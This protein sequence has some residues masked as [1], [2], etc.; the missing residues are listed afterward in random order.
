MSLNKKQYY[1]SGRTLKSRGNQ[2]MLNS[3]EKNAYNPTR[4]L[5]K[6]RESFV[7]PE[8][9]EMKCGGLTK[10]PDGG[11]TKKSMLD[12]S[13]LTYTPST[14]AMNAMM[15]ARLAYANEFGNPS[16]KRMVVAPDQP[17]VYTGEEYDKDFD[18]PA[19]VPA[20]SIG[21]HYM[22]EFDN[23]AVPFIQQGPK[24]LYFNES[25]SISDKEAIRFDSPEDA[26]Y[27]AQH[28]KEVAPDP[29]Y[30]EEENIPETYNLQRALELGYTPDETGHMPSVD[31][32][33]GM[34]LKSIDHPTSWK[35]YLY[36]SLNRELG[37]NYNVR[38][39]PEGYFGKRQL[40]YV[41]KK[42]GGS[43]PKMDNGGGFLDRYAFNMQ[44]PDRK[45]GLTIGAGTQYGTY[46]GLTGSLNAAVPF[47]LNPRDVG[48][49]SSLQG[50]VYAGRTQFGPTK[51]VSLGY[52]YDNQ[53][54]K[55]FFRGDAGYDQQL[56][57]MGTVQAGQRF[58]FELRDKKR[59]TDYTGSFGYGFGVGLHSKNDPRTS[60]VIPTMFYGSNEQRF[61][62]TPA[63]RNVKYQLGLQGDISR[64][65]G[66][67]KLTLFGKANVDPTQ[68]KYR[69]RDL[70]V[71]VEEDRR[72]I[73]A[74]TSGQLE[75]SPS[76]T[77]GAKYDINKQ[78]KDRKIQS[79]IEKQKAKE[80][81][82]LREQEAIARREEERKRKQQEESEFV[83]EDRKQF[84]GEV[85][86]LT[87]KEIKELR[88]GGHIVI[89]Q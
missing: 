71:P 8:L 55:S 15:K 81:A 88:K 9:K 83:K 51:G 21:T 76:F 12:N 10:M 45:K 13:E 78:F 75:W 3:I 69:R 2:T 36:G 54:Y 62:P 79:R 73:D 27:F 67:G 26:S 47:K 74:A 70:S 61:T 87:D 77:V 85:M 30:R 28:Y 43:I 37:S 38:V 4:K 35:E 14:D 7:N 68:G 82:I 42:N 11:P 24:G 18:R 41:S 16:A 44:D 89:E 66:P 40:Q 49:L 39:N 59:R 80:E 64:E 50:S 48:G 86:E 56:G 25:P 34:W 20:G 5:T 17:Y 65:L 60:D 72:F 29:S 63:D 22:A 52:G 58:P 46:T 32:E 33:T 53:K 1:T 23:Y 84:G 6:E 19:G 57:A 31:E